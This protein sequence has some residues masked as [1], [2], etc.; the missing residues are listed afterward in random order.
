MTY[1]GHPLP[2]L[3]DSSITKF[4]TCPDDWRRHYLLGERGPASGSMFLGKRIDDV[5]TT[6]YRGLI[7]GTASA[8]RS[9][10]A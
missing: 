9:R 3:S 8:R 6:Y 2:V 4:L 5:L 10:S 1:K 7:G